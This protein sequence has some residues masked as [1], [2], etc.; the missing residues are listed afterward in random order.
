MDKNNQEKYFFIKLK[1]QRKSKNISID[2]VCKDTKINK[3]YIEAI[4]NGDLDV[5]PKLNLTLKVM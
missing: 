2:D 5:L 3:E 4:E 1:E